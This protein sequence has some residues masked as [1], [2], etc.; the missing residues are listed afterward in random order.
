MMRPSLAFTNNAPSLASAADAATNL[1]MVEMM[2][3]APLSLIGKVV[4][5]DPAKEEMTTDTAASGRRIQIRG[6][7]M[8]VQDGKKFYA[9]GF[10]VI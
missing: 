9:S 4:T 6:I 2:W 7:V 1:R 5:W 8:D 3:M 10:S